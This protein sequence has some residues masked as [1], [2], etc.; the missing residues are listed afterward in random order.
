MKR[1]NADLIRAQKLS[2]RLYRA[3][4]KAEALPIALEL[5]EKLTNEPGLKQRIENNLQEEQS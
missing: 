5:I 4:S 3:R 2:R 1:L